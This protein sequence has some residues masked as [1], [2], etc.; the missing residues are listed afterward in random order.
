MGKEVVNAVGCNR[1]KILLK[2]TAKAVSMKEGDSI[3]VEGVNGTLSGDFRKLAEKMKKR[4]LLTG[5]TVRI[6]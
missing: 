2:V 5:T 1:T 3:E 6:F 4:F